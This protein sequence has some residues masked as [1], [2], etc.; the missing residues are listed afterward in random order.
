MI[1]FQQLYYIE[2]YLKRSRTQVRIINIGSPAYR[3]GT[4]G[5]EIGSAIK[6]GETLYEGMCSMVGCANTPYYGYAFKMFPFASSLQQRFQLR[7]IDMSPFQVATNIWPA[8]NGKLRHPG[9][10]DYYVDRVRVIFEDAVPYQFGGE[11]MGY[12]K[13][14]TFSL[15]QK[16]IELI[17]KG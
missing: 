9:L 13:E 15:S 16:P 17:R 2:S 8:W 12:R 1:R 11:A 4:N 14:I 10:H 7:I 3:I 5:E 6:N